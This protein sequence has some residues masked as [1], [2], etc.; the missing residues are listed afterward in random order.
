MDNTSQ[1]VFSSGLTDGSHT[2]RFDVE[3]T[4]ATTKNTK[5]GLNG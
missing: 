1:R 4:P 2:L 5:S 3:R